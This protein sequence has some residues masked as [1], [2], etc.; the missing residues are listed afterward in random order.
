MKNVIDYKPVGVCSKAFHI[1]VE[2]GK[3][4]SLTADGG[5]NGNLKGLSSLLIDMKV[6][7]AI[8]KL[9]GI[10]CKEKV[11]SCPDQIALA[12]QEYMENPDK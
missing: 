1:T 11:T 4:K 12:L 9:N 6:T 5:C 8:E 7:E 10:T 3:I 2:A